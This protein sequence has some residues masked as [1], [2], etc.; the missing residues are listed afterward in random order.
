MIITLNEF[1]T[2][3]AKTDN[4]VAPNKML[5][6]NNQAIYNG[7][8]NR[9][10]RNIVIKNLH[11]Y[12]SNNLLLYK[13]LYKRESH[14]YPLSIKIIIYTVIN[15]GNISMRNGK[16]N[17]KPPKKGYKPTWDIENL[18]SI[19]I[20]AINDSLTLNGFIPDDNIAYIDNI[21]YEYIEV[22]NFKDRKIEIH[23]DE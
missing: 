11:N 15:H 21:S 3:I 14:N 5:K 19:W 12:I 8:L 18:A 16:V 13:G 22:K 17:W 9:F 6:I 23:I 7:S 20:K 10:S 1:P 2:H 4:K